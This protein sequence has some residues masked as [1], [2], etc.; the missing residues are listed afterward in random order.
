MRQGECNGC[1]ACCRFLIL[2]VNPQYMAA[3]R[4][5]WIELH[6]IRLYERDGGVW[7]V[8]N[9]ACS[10]L[11][12]EGRCGLF[13]LPER[14]QTCAEFPFVQPDIDQVDDWA[15][16]KVCSYSFSEEVTV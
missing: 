16:E 2:Q 13:G 14:P 3:D 12:D 7:A 6:G 5:R 1:A 10:A 11:T 8:V 9:A 15:G 4:R